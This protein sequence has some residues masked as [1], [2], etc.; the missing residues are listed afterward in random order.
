MSRYNNSLKIA[1]E[2]LHAI[3][4]HKEKQKS[5][6]KLQVSNLWLMS[7]CFM[8]LYLFIFFLDGSQKDIKLL[9]FYFQMIHVFLFIKRFVIFWRFCLNRNKWKDAW[10]RLCVYY[11]WGQQHNWKWTVPIT[12]YITP[13]LKCFDRYLYSDPNYYLSSLIFQ[14]I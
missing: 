2:L 3:A 6:P 14:V 9:W 1:P 10:K 4:D 5:S 11:W 12:I 13:F 8:L 7:P